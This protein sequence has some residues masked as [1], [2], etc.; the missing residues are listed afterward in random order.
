MRHD[1]R[2]KDADRGDSD[3]GDGLTASK[4]S[5][6]ESPFRYRLI[7]SYLFKMRNSGDGGE[8]R[9]KCA[10]E[11]GKRVQGKKC[12]KVYFHLEKSMGSE[13]FP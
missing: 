3:K 4:T 12:R 6:N 13:Y 11:K 1:T 7:I 10:W 8:K 5:R 9:L 2:V